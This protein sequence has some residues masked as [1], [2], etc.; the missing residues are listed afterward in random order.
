MTK[1]VL[2]VRLKAVFSG[3]SLVGTPQREF[4]PGRG[5][6]RTGTTTTNARTQHDSGGSR[7]STDSRQEQTKDKRTTLLV[8]TEDGTRVKVVE[9]DDPTRSR[10]GNSWEVGR[11]GLST[12]RTGRLAPVTAR[13]TGPTTLLNPTGTTN[14]PRVTTRQTELCLPRSCTESSRGIAQRTSRHA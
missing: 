1:P 3:T 11:R 2:S 5:P 14:S 4:L 12:R 8:A 9:L 7:L 6:L 10:H 13:T